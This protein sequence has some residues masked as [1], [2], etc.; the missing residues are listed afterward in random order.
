MRIP[1]L[2][3]L[4][5][6]IALCVGCSSYT[7]R[8]TIVDGHDPAIGISQPTVMIV[9]ADDPRLDTGGLASSTVRVTLDPDAMNPADAGTATTDSAGRFAMPIGGGAGFLLYDIRV[10]AR[11]AGH[12]TADQ[13]MP[14][15]RGNKRLLI[16]LPQG[17]DQWE[18]PT[19]FVDETLEMGKPYMEGGR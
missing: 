1:H 13:I 3:V 10:L 4:L 9:D 19:D 6:L 14:L 18:E 7:L 16:V 2:I 15:P 8:G 5:G 11:R 12:L 17:E